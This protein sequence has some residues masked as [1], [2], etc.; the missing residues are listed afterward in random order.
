MCARELKGGPLEIADPR[1]GP[2]HGVARISL[3]QVETYARNPVSVQ[4]CA[5][6]A[7]VETMPPTFSNPCRRQLR[8]LSSTAGVIS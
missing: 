4:G 6:G 5:E 8:T 7:V 1:E 3:N 2:V